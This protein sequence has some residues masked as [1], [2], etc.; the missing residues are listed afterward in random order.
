MTTFTTNSNNIDEPPQSRSQTI[1]LEQPLEDKIG[2]ET[3]EMQA[4]SNDDDE[5]PSSALDYD[6]ES[7]GSWKVEPW[8]HAFYHTTTSVLGLMAIVA[9]PGS[10]AYL[11]WA[12]GVV[13]LL[14]STVVSYLSGVL[15]IELQEPHM[16]T[17]S[18]IAD[19]VM[20]PRFS[21]FFIR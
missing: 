6:E 16:R 8:Q 9:L 2:A 14:A 13:L 7:E 11:G 15:I 1:Y 3:A 12:G 21:Y 20:F 4:V 5:N 10:F 18:E 19:A 17:Y